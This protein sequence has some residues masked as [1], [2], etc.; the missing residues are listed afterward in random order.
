ML[1]KSIILLSLNSLILCFLKKYNIKNNF[2][3]FAN[4]EYKNIK[5]Y[6][7]QETWKNQ[8]NEELFII[9]NSIQLA[10]GDINKLLRRISVNNKFINNINIQ[11]ENQN[12]LDVIS[13]KILK[14]YVCCSG[15]VNLIISEEEEKQCYCTNI[16]DNMS[17]NGNYIVVFDPLDGSTN[18]DSGLPTGTIFGI[19]KKNQFQKFNSNIDIKKGNQLIAAGYC[20]YSASTNLVLSYGTGVHMFMFDDIY[21]EFLLINNNI[22]I[23]KNGNIYSFNDGYYN[24]WSSDIKKY[25]NNLKNNK[26][27]ARYFGALVADTHNILLNGGIFGYPSTLNNINGKLRLVYEANPISKIIN[28]AGGISTNGT[29]NILDLKINNIHQRTPLFFGSIEEIIKLQNLLN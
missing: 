22:T 21:N 25:Y 2:R 4:N 19:Y 3:L 28:D 14:S 27:K 26:N 16:V 23:P 18:I 10:C 8:E 1:L 24:Q 6:F 7:Q 9:L 12:N 13:N 17:F 5:N 11:G 20:L 29:H 15:K